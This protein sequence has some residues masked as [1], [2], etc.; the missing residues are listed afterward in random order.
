MSKNVCS[1]SNASVQRCPRHVRFDSDKPAFH[2]ALLRLSDRLL[3]S[4]GLGVLVE[5]LLHQTPPASLLFYFTL[6]VS[7]SRGASAKGTRIAESGRHNIVVHRP[8][9]GPSHA[10]RASMLCSV[11]IRVGE[12]WRCQSRA[13]PKAATFT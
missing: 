9:F 6:A 13:M 10:G 2:L 5:G 3:F 7:S 11:P 4:I 1:E 8:H 12:R